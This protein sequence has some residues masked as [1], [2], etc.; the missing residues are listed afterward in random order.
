[1]I[2]III[3]SVILVFIV[4][5]ILLIH[6]HFT[7]W[8][9]NNKG[10]C[11]KV[12]SSNGPKSKSDCLRNCDIQPINTQM[13]N[14]NNSPI[15]YNCNNYTN[16]CE[17]ALHGPGTFTTLD[18]CNA[19]CSPEPVYVNVPVIARRPR[20]WGPRKFGRWYGPRKRR[21]RRH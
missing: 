1:M 18:A 8:H 21:G 9:C 5:A 12:F 6:F 3:I 2:Y 11:E 19:N 17:E 14:T 16:Q 20:Y 10:E 15:G 7:R 4:S 13:N